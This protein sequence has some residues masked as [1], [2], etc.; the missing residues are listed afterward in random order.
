MKKTIYVIT[1]RVTGKTYIGQTSKTIEQRFK[2]HIQDSIYGTKKNKLLYEAIRMYGKENFQIDAIET[3]DESIADQRE[4]FWIKKFQSFGEN[5]YNATIGGQAYKP[6]YYETIA[7]YLQDGKGTKEII[8]EIGCCRDLIY[9]VAHIYGLQIPKSSHNKPIIQLSTDMRIVHRF[10]S[11][12]EAAI[13]IS[14]TMPDTPIHTIRSSISRCCNQG[15]RKTAY[16][17]IWS[18]DVDTSCDTNR[19]DNTD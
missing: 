15:N 18:H 14:K 1:N 12:G 4:Q 17:F 2:K 9:K 10:C 3:C 13:A 19:Q 8:A 6:Y 5:G 11:I 16:G 7:N